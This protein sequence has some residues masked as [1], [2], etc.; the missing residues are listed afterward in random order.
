VLARFH[1]ARAPTILPEQDFNGR[2]AAA[3]SERTT[4]AH[5]PNPT[6]DPRF[7]K[8]SR[9]RADGRSSGSNRIGEAGGQCCTDVRRNG[10]KMGE[11]RRGLRR[12][13]RLHEHGFTLVELLI[14]LVVAGIIIGSAMPSFASLLQNKRLLSQRD[15]FV[16]ALRYARSTALSQNA[17]TQVCPFSASGSTTCG[18]NWGAGWIVVLNPAGSATSTP[19]LTLLQSVQAAAAAPAVSSPSSAATVSFD[20]RGLATN[21]AQFVICD[22]RG[23]AYAYSVQIYPTG[24][25]ELGATAGNALWGGAIACP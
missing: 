21:A 6:A 11:S 14:T 5:P 7:F 4:S 23:S 2:G 9:M 12:A 16:A 24:F 22:S 20:P 3:G 19:P 1:A 8:P 17:A 18:T 13:N 10:T 25:S 15:A